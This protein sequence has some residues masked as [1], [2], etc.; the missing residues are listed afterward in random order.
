MVAD[1][2][3]L[4]APMC[5]VGGETPY[6]SQEGP[7]TFPLT[8]V[9]LILQCLMSTWLV[10][11]IFIILSKFTLNS[12]VGG[13]TLRGRGPPYFLLCIVSFGDTCSVYVFL[14]RIVL[15]CTYYLSWVFVLCLYWFNLVIVV[16]ACFL[17]P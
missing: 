17:S 1:L 6:T 3:I 8:G 13:P 14:S 15:I 16:V 9:S 10:S 5:P 4:V 7:S 11:S 12:S 2:S